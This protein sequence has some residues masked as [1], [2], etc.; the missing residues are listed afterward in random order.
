MMRAVP[1][2]LDELREVLAVH[3][4]DPSYALR[5]AALGVRYYGPGDGW[6]PP[7]YVAPPAPQPVC[8]L[9]SHTPRGR[10]ARPAPP[11]PA[12]REPLGDLAYWTHERMA[13]LREGLRAAGLTEVRPGVFQWRPHDR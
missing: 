5:H 8:E 6:E 11:P 4:A 1:P 13:R 9:K 7:P 12:P 2:S 3:A 10:P